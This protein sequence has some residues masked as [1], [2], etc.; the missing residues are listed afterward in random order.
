MSSEDL[1]QRDFESGDFAVH[2]D[3]G[4]VQLHLETNVDIGSVDSG[5]PPQ[6]EPPVGNLV[7]P[8]ALS[9]SQFFELH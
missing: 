4:E 3:P 7:E 5:G 2:E 6:R 9:V 8:R 1:D